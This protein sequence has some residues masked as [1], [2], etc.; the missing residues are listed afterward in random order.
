MLPA[1]RAQATFRNA[2]LDGEML[3]WNKRNCAFEPFKNI[4][5]VVF[6]AS[7]HLPAGQLIKENQV[8]QF[9]EDE[10]VVLSKLP[11]SEACKIANHSR[12]CSCTVGR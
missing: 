10:G 12:C 3:I 2:I 1:V 11:A 5:P 9:G 4:M 6:A 8:K 7:R